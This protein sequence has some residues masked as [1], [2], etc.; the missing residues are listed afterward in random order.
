MVSEDWKGAVII[1]LYK[2]KGTRTKCETY[3]GISLLS[4]VGKVYASILIE[5][6]KVI[7]EEMIEDEQGDFRHGRGCV[8]QI[9]CDE[10]AN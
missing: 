1:P 8:D 2:G 9:F 3:R 7:T 6:V 10:S 4:I 5:Q